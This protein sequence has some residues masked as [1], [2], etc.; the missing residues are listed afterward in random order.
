[1]WKKDYKKIDFYWG[2]K[3]YCLVE[4]YYKL[5]PKGAI[6]D[7]GCGEGRN[8]FFLSKKGFE[9]EAIDSEAAGIKKLKEYAESHKIKNIAVYAKD[10]TKFSLKKIYS[11][12][13]A[14][15]SLQFLK[16]SQTKKV[17]IKIK[18]KLSNN[19]III[20]TV[21]STNDPSFTY[22][23]SKAK[24]IET[25]TFQ[26]HQNR[27]VHFFTKKELENLFSEFKIILLKEKR[28]KDFHGEPHYHSV[29]DFVIKKKN[30]E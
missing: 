3:P 2:L 12:I 16:S 26:L 27:Y 21:F 14:I 7:I 18:E 11:G 1:M 5:I 22:I 10:I 23:K 15:N 29:F 28:F 8:S 19:G 13:V 25:N 20:I 4:K 9:I 6:L 30:K 17:V 24:E